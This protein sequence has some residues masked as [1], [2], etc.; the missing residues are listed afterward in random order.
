MGFRSAVLKYGGSS[1][2]AVGPNA[3]WGQQV[4]VSWDEYQ[5]ANGENA[6]RLVSAANQ[7][8]ALKCT[9][10][11]G[12]PLAVRL[13]SAPVIPISSI[14]PLRRFTFQT[15]AWREALT[16]GVPMNVGLISGYANVSQVVGSFGYEFIS[17]STV[18]A[19]RWTV[20]RKLSEVAAAADVA[21]SGVTPLNTPVL[22]EWVYTEGAPSTLEG[23]VAGTRVYITAGN[24][25]LPASSV[26]PNDAVYFSPSVSA[27]ADPGS[28]AGATD[29]FTGSRLLIEDLS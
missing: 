21:D 26:L 25:D 5:A 4:G 1:T 23:K 19:G 27:G 17:L 15:I 13:G 3:F 7:L 20:R 10:I 14:R 24:A 6:F 22:L 11:A 8:G 28:A 16:A 12:F 29:W 2:P 18:N 9:L